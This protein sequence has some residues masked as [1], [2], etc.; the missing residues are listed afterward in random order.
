M[1]KSIFTLILSLLAPYL[2]LAGEAETN[3]A[4]PRGDAYF[5]VGNL[6]KETSFTEFGRMSSIARWL[7]QQGF[8]PILNPFATITDLREA[9]QNDRAAL[10]I[11]SSHGSASGVIRDA[12]QTEVPTSTL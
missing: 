12:R 3:A 7:A 6:E 11:W 5:L 8:R 9:V 10:I 2:L 4:Y 1:R